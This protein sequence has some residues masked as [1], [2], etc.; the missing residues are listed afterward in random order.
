MVT[1]IIVVLAVAFL[2]MMLSTSFVDREVS[3]DVRRRTAGRRMLGEWVDKLSVAMTPA[4][5]AAR[6]AGAQ[7]GSAAWKELL[8]WGGLGE[9]H[10]GRIAAL[11]A[12]QQKYE[13]YF[14]AIEPGERSAVVGSREG[15]AIFAHLTEPANL[16]EFVENVKSV[17]MAFPTSKEKLEGFVSEFAE[18]APLRQKVLAGHAAAV[19]GLKKDLGA[20]PVLSLLGGGQAGAFEL[21]LRHGFAPDPG[22]FEV[23][24]EEAVLAMQ[25]ETLVALLHNKRMRGVIAKRIG[26]DVPELVPVHVFQVASSKKGSAWLKQEVERTRQEVLEQPEQ[27]RAELIEPLDISAER[28]AHVA[29]VRLKVGRLADIEASLPEDTGDAWLGFGTR[30]AWLIIISFVVCVVGVANAMLMS[31]TERFREIATMKCL[32]ALDSVIMVMFVMESSLQGLAGGLVGVVLG[33]LLG[34]MRSLWGFGTLALVNLPGVILLG[35]AGACLVAGVVLAAAAA[36]YPAWVAARLAP[37]EAM[38]IE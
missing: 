9:E 28:I 15:D 13:R 8:G 29:S 7:P 20:T 4:G 3:R 27:K 22:V 25:A 37:M 10:L 30:T 17:R 6:L 35:S 19:A 26:A 21:L 2:M 16:A 36:V 24:K 33:L 31:V 14:A 1:V 18:T 23:L 38:R 34:I 12:R 5:L 11:A 32:G